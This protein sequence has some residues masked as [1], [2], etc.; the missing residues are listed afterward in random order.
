MHGKATGKGLGGPAS[1]VEFDLRESPGL[2]K[3]CDPI[4]RDS[5]VGLPDPGTLGFSQET[6]ASANTFVWE[7]AALQLSP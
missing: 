3:Q 6:M 2:G 4:A 5:D 1:S 7:K